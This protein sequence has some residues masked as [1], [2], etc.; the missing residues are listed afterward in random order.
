[1]CINRASD[2]SAVNRRRTTLN[3][4]R[5]QSGLAPIAGDDDIEISLSEDSEEEMDQKPKVPY[6]NIKL[7]EIYRYIL[8]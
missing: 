4:L 7:H 8:I 1:M 5:R 3:S 6:S 2:P